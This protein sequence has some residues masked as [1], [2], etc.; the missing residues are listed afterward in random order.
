M[1]DMLMAFRY[2]K[3]ALIKSTMLT[4]LRKEAPTALT[5]DASG[6][7]VGTVLQQLVHGVWQP[8][9]LFRNH[10]RP[11]ER[12]YSAFGRELLAL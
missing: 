10:L 6:E 4:H 11:A 3:E 2:A 12:K 8:L 5:T 7:A 1:E 9:A